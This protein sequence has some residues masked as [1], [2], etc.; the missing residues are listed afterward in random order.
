M[1]KRYA[2]AKNIANN[3]EMFTKVM[4]MKEEIKKDRR[5]LKPIKG[6]TFEDY[7]RV[8]AHLDQG[9]PESELLEILGVSKQVLD[10]ALKKWNKKLCRLIDYNP[11]FG[12]LY[13]QIYFNPITGRF[14]K[15]SAKRITSYETSLQNSAKN[16]LAIPRP[17]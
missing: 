6:I 16:K 10:E 14:A 2:E 12:E 1:N 4:T 7:A 11:E 3:G 17:S 8:S 13:G 15:R 9:V 5:R